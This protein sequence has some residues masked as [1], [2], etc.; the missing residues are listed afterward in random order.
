MRPADFHDVDDTELTRFWWD[1]TTLHRVHQSITE[2]RIMRENRELEG[3]TLEWGRP[4]LRMSFAQYEMLQRIFPD[5]KP[6]GDPAAR[7]RVIEKI[8]SDPDFRALV[9]G[10]A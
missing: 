1:D 8:A 9:I 7:R 3:R 10:K 4:V 6:G 2:D 5:F